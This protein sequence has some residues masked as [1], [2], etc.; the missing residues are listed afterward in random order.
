MASPVPLKSSNDA[1]RDVLEGRQALE[2][3]GLKGMLFPRAAA[4]VARPHVCCGAKNASSLE[5]TA[6]VVSPLL[7]RGEILGK[8]S[9]DQLHTVFAPPQA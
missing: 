1:K 6:F 7:S 4:G 3:N 9:E 5:A 2:D 8:L